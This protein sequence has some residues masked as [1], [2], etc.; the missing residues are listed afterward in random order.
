MIKKGMIVTIRKKVT[1]E[2]KVSSI[3]PL[4]PIQ[5]VFKLVI[6]V[7]KYFQCCCIHFVYKRCF[8]LSKDLHN[9][10]VGF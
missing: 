5:Q 3:S 4:K 7:R 1:A 2:R 10:Q 9:F 8:N 6:Y